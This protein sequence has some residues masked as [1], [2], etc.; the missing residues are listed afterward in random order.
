MQRSCILAICVPIFLLRLAVAS[1][2]TESIPPGRRTSVPSNR[3]GNPQGQP[4]YILSPP[5]AECLP[6]P[7]P[8][9]DIVRSSNAPKITPAQ[10]E[11][12][13]QPLPINLATAM[14][15]ADAR[16][17]VIQAAQASEFTTYAQWERARVLWLPDVYLGSDYQRH[18]GGQERTTGDVAIN[19]RNQFLAGGGLK[20]VFALTDAIYT[21]LAAKQLYRA[22]NYDVQAAKNDA[23]LS[24]TEA[25]FSVQQA[26]NFGRR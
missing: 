1:A 11:P 10:L 3:P 17:L 22:R 6:G 7:T 9:P 2:Q 19:D 12:I 16:P 4:S 24:V 26:R 13:D 18:D 14:R 8:L 21:P 25:F 20:A 15:L 5:D 23:L